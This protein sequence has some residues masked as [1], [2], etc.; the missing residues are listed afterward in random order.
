MNKKHCVM[1]IGGKTRVVTWGDDPDFPGREIITM[2][3]TFGDFASLQNKYRVLAWVW[4]KRKEMFVKQKVPLG[5]WWIKRPDRRQYDGGK[6]FMPQKDEQVVGNVMNTW[7][8]FAVQARKPEGRSG[9]TGCQL[10]LDHG[11]KIICSGNEEHYNYLIKREAFIA[12]NRVRSEIALALH[13]QEEGTGKGFW[14]RNRNRLFGLAAMQVQNPE[15][16]VGKHNEHLES[17]L[18]LTADEALFA[19]NPLHRNALF[20]MITEPTLTIEP[21]FIGVYLADNYLNIDVLS[22]SKHFIPVSGTARR[23]FVPTVSS[24]KKGNF[25]Y[26]KKI[27]EQMKNGGYEA[28]LYHL[29]YEVDVRDF[30]VRAVPKTAA[31]AEQAAYSRKGIDLLV[32]TA[33]NEACAPCQ[34]LDHPGYSMCTGTNRHAGRR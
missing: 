29:L 10:F 23:F 17:L 16:V 9:A 34:P 24:D 3:M 13:T 11:L 5:S 32:E 2:V 14:T 7:R 22:N 31:L 27:D 20:N 26:F 12:Q 15:H 4:D 6:R 33:C 19:L 30:N 1:P 18:H 28:L 8:G 25:D 21:K